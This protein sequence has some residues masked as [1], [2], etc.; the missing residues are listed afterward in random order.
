MGSRFGRE[1]GRPGEKGWQRDDKGRQYREEAGSRVYRSIEE[2]DEAV[3]EIY[4]TRPCEPSCCRSILAGVAA[5]RDEL[6][7]QYMHWCY[8][9]QVREAHDSE[10]VAQWEK[11]R[12]GARLYVA[13]HAVL[14]YGVR[15]ARF[16][17]RNPRPARQVRMQ[18][19]LSGEERLR[20]M[21]LALS[22]VAEGKTMSDGRLGGREWDERRSELRGQAAV[23]GTSEKEG[24]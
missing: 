6:V 24:A 21:Q 18:E 8:E 11:E 5:H 20:R 10:T 2:R 4:T 17:E 22:S 9:R 16:G 14:L 19:G 7:T 12:F 23:L 15:V 3:E 1:D 13:A